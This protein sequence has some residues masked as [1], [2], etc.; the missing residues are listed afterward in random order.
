M[1]ILSFKDV[2][3]RFRITVDTSLEN[4]ICVHLDD[5]GVLKF[6]E[7]ESGLYLLSSKNNLTNQKISAYS[8]L[9]LV[10][11]NKSDFT[12][13]QLKRAD[14]ARDFRRKIGYPGYRKYFML[15]ETNYFRNCPLT[16][17]DA[18][19]ALH[20]YGPDVESLKGKTVRKTP[21]AIEDMTRVNLPETLKDLHPHANLSVDYFL[22]RGLLF[23]IAS[24]VDM[25]LEQL[26]TSRTSVRN[27]ISQKC[28]Q[29]L[30][31]A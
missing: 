10:K 20:I 25:T 11:A 7:V 29:E 21:K 24:P 23:Y 2:R 14:L 19:R 30:K 3:E 27:I 9:N 1:N 31:S 26:K 18:K 5:G 13:R 12:K 6:K 8:F 28:S 17:D 15:L 4:A 22:C 16:V